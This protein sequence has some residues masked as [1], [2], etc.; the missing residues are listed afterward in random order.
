MLRAYGAEVVVCP[1]AVA[2][3]DPRL[4]LLGLRP[5]GP[6]DPRRLEAQ[7]VRQPEQPGSHYETTGPEIWEDTDGPDHPLRR[8]ASAPAAPSPAPAA[9]SRRSPAGRVQ[10]D[11][12]RPR[13]LGLLRRHRPAVPGRGRRRG[14]L[15]GRLRPRR[16]ADEIIA[17]SDA[18]SFAMT[19]RLAREEGLLVGGSCGMAVVGGAAAWP[20]GSTADDVV[21]VLLP[22]GGR[23][24]LSKIF[25]DDWMADYGFLD[26]GRRGDRRR[27]A[28]RARAAACPRWCTPIRTRPSATRSR[29]CTSTASRRCRWSRP[30]RR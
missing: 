19:R 25:S 20:S 26:Q 9:T 7:P 15:A 18:D 22:D 24:Y 29:S 14:L 4:L 21:V 28:A 23:G 2:P 17:V 6:R 13:G 10:V 30:S 27:R 8:R 11:R 1:T 5:A 3:E 12:R 16:S